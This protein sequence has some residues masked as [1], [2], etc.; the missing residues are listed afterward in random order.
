[1]YSR[2]PI[3]GITLHGSARVIIL[4]Y[5]CT[6]RQSAKLVLHYKVATVCKSNSADFDYMKRAVLLLVV[7]LQA[8]C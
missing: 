4:Q 8:Y 2:G 6:L 5:I 1:M 3:R 7:D